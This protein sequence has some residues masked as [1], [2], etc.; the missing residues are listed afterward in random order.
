M[1]TMARDQSVWEP[2]LLSSG[3]W[4]LSQLLRGS[5]LQRPRQSQRRN[6]GN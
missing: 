6:S 1:N 5:V 2:R 4:L 3:S